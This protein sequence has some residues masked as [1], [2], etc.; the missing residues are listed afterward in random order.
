MARNGPISGWL[1]SYS[2]GMSHH[3]AAGNILNQSG[4][5]VWKTGNVLFT[6]VGQQEINQI[7]AAG[8]L[9][10]SAEQAMPHAYRVSFRWHFNNLVP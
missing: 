1:K 2:E 7:V 5:L 10:P 4:E 9:R 8:V 3:I 6:D